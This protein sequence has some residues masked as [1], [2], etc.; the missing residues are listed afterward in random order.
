[1]TELDHTP[2]IGTPLFEEGDPGS[3]WAETDEAGNTDMTT[4]LTE[5]RGSTDLSF[6]PGYDAEGVT[7][8]LPV[9]GEQADEPEESDEPLDEPE[10]SVVPVAAA[11]GDVAVASVTRQAHRHRG[12][13]DRYE[14]DA[15]SDAPPRGNSVDPPKKP[16][17]N[18]RKSSPEPEEPHDGEGTGDHAEHPEDG[19]ALQD[20]ERRRRAPN[21]A[22][23]KLHIIATVLDGNKDLSTILSRREMAQF[24][25]LS[26]PIAEVPNE[27][28]AE[29]LM[30]SDV[31]GSNRRA[32]QLLGFIEERTQSLPEVRKMLPDNIFT[33][34][35]PILKE[36]PRDEVGIMITEARKDA[37]LTMAEGAVLADKSVSSILRLE[38]GQVRVSLTELRIILEGWG[39]APSRVDSIVGKYREVRMDEREKR[40]AQQQPTAAEQLSAAQARFIADLSKLGIGVSEAV[41]VHS[42]A[43]TQV[44]KLIGDG[45]TNQDIARQLDVP[46]S[47][48]TSHV[49]TIIE[50]LDERYTNMVPPELMRDVQTI[51]LNETIVAGRLMVWRKQGGLTRTAFAGILGMSESS[52][53]AYETAGKIPEPWVVR[54]YLLQTGM[55]EADIDAEM[56]AFRERVRLDRQRNRP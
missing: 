29:R 1:M 19:A 33:P 54:R 52:L 42:P 23:N 45:M 20:G 55:P 53:E 11:A 49:A 5:A 8:F 12:G 25:V 47:V 18:G 6:V 35:G 2:A 27:D 36:E 22:R 31:A 13:H 26:A 7:D 10:A 43:A 39:T 34:E 56:D 14:Q 24:K 21:E 28:A 46:P 30:Y 41:G 40:R 44:V 37:G 16:P 50:K 3:V 38:H 17:I 15:P 32:E 4:E 51:D 9:R 48:V